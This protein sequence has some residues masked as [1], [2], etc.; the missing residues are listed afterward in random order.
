MCAK[1]ITLAVQAY[2]PR[3]SCALI[4]HWRNIDT[5]SL[6][7]KSA[8]AIHAHGSDDIQQQAVTLACHDF[9]SRCC[10]A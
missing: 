1:H 9:I 10:C 5:V 4:D 7:P 6:K 8:V 3:P 2:L